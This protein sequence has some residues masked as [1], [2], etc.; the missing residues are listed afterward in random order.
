MEH[1]LCVSSDEFFPIVE[2]LDAVGAR[3][4]RIEDDRGG[5]DS[6]VIYYIWTKM[7]PD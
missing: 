3:I 2:W 6:W 4:M 5:S 1:K 7:Q